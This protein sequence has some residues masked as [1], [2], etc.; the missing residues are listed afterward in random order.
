MRDVFFETAWRKKN[1]GA[2]LTGVYPNYVQNG[3]FS[4]PYDWSPFL[5]ATLDG[6]R[7]EI[8]N[9]LYY[10]SF[11][12]TLKMR[13][14][15]IGVYE[16]YRWAIPKTPISRKIVKFSHAPRSASF[17]HIHIPRFS[18]IYF[19]RSKLSWWGTGGGDYVT[20]QINLNYL[21]ESET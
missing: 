1:N 15:L 3:N 13:Y 9:L 4:N 5:A 16:K 14:Y 18:T 21:L 17:G 7:L 10:Y 19:N 11:I 20:E 12:N 2:S 6:V 8:Y